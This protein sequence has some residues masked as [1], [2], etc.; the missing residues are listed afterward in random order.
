MPYAKIGFRPAKSKPTEIHKV[1][2]EE[3]CSQPINNIIYTMLEWRLAMKKIHRNA[4]YLPQIRITL[5][6]K[7]ELLIHNRELFSNTLYSSSNNTPIHLV[8]QFNGLRVHIQTVNYGKRVW[9]IGNIARSNSVFPLHEWTNEF[10]FRTLFRHRNPNRSCVSTNPVAVDNWHNVRL[11]NRIFLLLP[12]I[13][14]TT[15]P[16]CIGL[17]N[18]TNTWGSNTSYIH[19]ICT[20]SSSLSK[21]W[22]E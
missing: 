3:Y 12:P 7:Q 4:L 8:Q 13:S 20:L 2:T 19:R 6:E 17:W 14:W 11:H 5:S 15:C 21:T 1:L 16:V 10:S 22:N 18:W 9:V